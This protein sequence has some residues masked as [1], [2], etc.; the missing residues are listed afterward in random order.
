MHNGQ[1]IIVSFAVSVDDQL[2]DSCLHSTMD[3]SQIR[4]GPFTLGAGWILKCV[5]HINVEAR[6]YACTA[7]YAPAL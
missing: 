1:V 7:I 3:A 2:S 5:C 4:D 6:V